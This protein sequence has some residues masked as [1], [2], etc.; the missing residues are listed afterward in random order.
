VQKA[1]A[2]GVRVEPGLPYPLGV[3]WTG[4]GANVALFSANAERV[5]LSIFDASGRREAARV[6]LPERTDDVWHGFLPDAR[7]GMLYGFRV[8]GAYDPARG[9]RFNHHKLLLDPYARALSGRLVWNDAHFGYRVGSPRADLSFDRRDNARYMPKS[10]LVE[11]A[12]SWGDDRPP[13]V[14][15][16]RTLIYEAHVKGLTR[17]HPDV[18]G[19][20]RGTYAAL[21]SPAMIDHLSA[22]G[23]TAVELLPVHAFVDDRRLVDLG[24]KNYWGYNSLGF[25]APETR[26][27]PDDPVAQFQV[28]VAE[29]HAAGIEVILDVVY[30]HTAEGNHLGPTFSFRGIDNASYYWLVPG[31]ER[32]Y[33]DFTGCG[34]SLDMRQPRVIQM[35]LDSLRYWVEVM[36]VDGFRFDLATELCRGPNGFDPHASF[37][38][39]VLQDPVLA[40]VKL[41]AEPW[42]LG[43]EGY[44][45]GGFPPG[46]SEWNDRF[47]QTVRRF[48]RG[49]DG[50]VG[51]L[52][53]RLAGSADVFA[54]SR[55]RPW[56]SINYVTCHDGFTLADLVS[57]ARKH[58]DANGE[59]NRDGHDDNQSANWGAEGP[60]DDPQIRALRARMMRNFMGTLFASQGVPMMLAGDER[61]RTQ[62]GNNN[63]YALDNPVSWVDWGDN[64]EASS[65]TLFVAALARLRR[66]HPALSQEHFLGGHETVSG[67]KD[68]TWLRPDAVEMQAS[69]WRFHEARFLGMMLAGVPHET[70]PPVLVLLHALGAAIDVVLPAPPRWPA[71]RCEIDTSLAGGIDGIRRFRAGAGITMPSRAFILLVAEAEA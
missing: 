52:A 13:R 29:L 58:N 22:L 50:M 11:A 2:G 8:S 37:L 67:L 24:L 9:H 41:I 59:G 47:R 33:M 5:D 32:H 46:W 4:R 35:V 49:E 30:N 20:I 17:L 54:A 25:F 70:A 56:A 36:H 61:A 51:D 34:N 27:G 69:D 55:R 39:A 23:V 18:P 57:Y 16:A 53:A 65:M 71:W 31:D 3:T 7:P 38:E 40:R 48:W 42:D 62:R 44:R 15:W 64:A 12:A 66:V 28:M 21:G 10:V 60:T 26:Y 1:A 19:P 43:P 6:R 63:A 68:V 14:P 45:L